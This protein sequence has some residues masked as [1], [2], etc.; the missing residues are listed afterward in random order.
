MLVQWFGST[1]GLGDGA[2]AL[3][4]AAAFV[5]H[6]WPVFFRFAGGKGVATAAGVLLAFDP[7][8]CAA[9]LATWLVVVVLS[10][11][12]SLASIAAAVFAPAWYL[13]GGG[14]LWQ[15]SGQ[16]ALAMIVMGLLLIWRHRENIRRLLAGTESR[17]G[18]GKAG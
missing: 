15:A 2:Q 4:G 16:K 12:V 7:W 10:R 17:L 5:G 8:L 3:V 6:L 18:G 13:L 14:V 11:Y 1:Y 9:V